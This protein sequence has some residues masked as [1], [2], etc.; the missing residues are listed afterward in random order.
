[1]AHSET[2]RVG[3]DRAQLPQPV[4]YYRDCGLRL[5]GQGKWRITWCSFCEYHTLRVNVKTGAYVCTDC[6]AS[7]SDILEHH[8]E[9]TGA[10][11]VQAAKGLG[12]WWYA[13]E[14][15]SSRQEVR[16]GL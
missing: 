8:M 7:G 9:V 14:A 3:L 10:D 11:E 2:R 12:A 5:D 16:R 4:D 15:P 6:G 1:M 13:S